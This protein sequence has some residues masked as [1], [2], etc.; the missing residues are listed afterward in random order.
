MNLDV[1]RG[2]VM[3]KCPRL[4]GGCEMVAGFKVGMLEGFTHVERLRQAMLL[5]AFEE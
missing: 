5:S 3:R 2:E 4:R 1:A